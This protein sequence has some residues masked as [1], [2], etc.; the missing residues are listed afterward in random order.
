MLS[1]GR[2]EIWGPESTIY[3]WKELL[4]MNKHNQAEWQKYSS[5]YN[6]SQS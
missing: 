4:K 2:Y 6:R 3:Y 1:F 5:S